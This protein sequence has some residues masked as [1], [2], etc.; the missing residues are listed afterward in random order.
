MPPQLKQDLEQFAV[1]IGLP[2]SRVIED[3]IGNMLYKHKE[4][5]KKRE[6]DVKTM[7]KKIAVCSNKGGV[8]KTTAAACLGH[9]LG[10]EGFRVLLI[11]ADPQGNLSNRFGYDPT[12]HHD[13]QLSAAINNVLGNSPISSKNFICKTTYEN[14]ELIPADDR[15]SI[16]KN[17]LLN[18]IVQININAYKAIIE[19]VESDYDYI[20]FDTRPSLDEEIAQILFCVDWI[21]I[22]VTTGHDSIQGASQTIQ[23]Q[24][25]CKRGNKNLQVAGVFFNRVNNRTISAQ[26]II[27]QLNVALDGYIFKT[28][29]PAVEDAVKSENMSRPITATFPKSKVTK[30][31]RELAKEVQMKIG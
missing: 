29:I 17:E 1:S 30:A 18:A 13:I 19:D 2:M 4:H 24:V 26:E 11:D 23:Y 5:K 12:E 28:I 22:P 16:S 9:I 20:I 25:K 21:I 31:F 15:L 6:G 7:A 8:G 14:V 10:Q 27:P 3:S